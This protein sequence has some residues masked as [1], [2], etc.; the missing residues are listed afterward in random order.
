MSRGRELLSVDR[1]CSRDLQ[2]NQEGLVGIT[3]VC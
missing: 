3:Q 2:A 1:I